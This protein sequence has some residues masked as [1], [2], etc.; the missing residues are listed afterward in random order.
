[1]SRVNR[2]PLSL[3]RLI[4]HMK[5]KVLNSSSCTVDIFLHVCRVSKS[6]CCTFLILVVF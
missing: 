5:G 4:A 3:S 6:N 2:P 1:M